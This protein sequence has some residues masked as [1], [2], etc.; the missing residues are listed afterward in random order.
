MQHNLDFYDNHDGGEVI[1]YKKCNHEHK[2]FSTASVHRMKVLHITF[3]YLFQL[4]SV[5]AGCSLC[6]A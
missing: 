2:I 3:L 4:W 1:Q 5:M 6:N